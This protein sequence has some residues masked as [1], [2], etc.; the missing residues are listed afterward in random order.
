MPKSNLKCPRNPFE[1]QQKQGRDPDLA[2]ILSY[3]HPRFGTAVVRASRSLRKHGIPHMLIGG[4]AIGAYGHVR[5]TADVDFLVGDEAFELFNGGS[6][7]TFSP[8]VPLLVGEVTI[9]SIP[10]DRDGSE[11]FLAEAMAD[12]PES[13][14]VPVAPPEVL[15]YL[16]LK[17]G[18]Q[19]DLDDVRQLVRLTGI[20]QEEVVAYLDEHSAYTSSATFRR[21]V[22]KA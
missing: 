5:A 4:V 6:L 20:S 16:K 14:G 18:R 12:A 8:G 22:E 9:D 13:D 7:V 21:L 3:L 2:H 1:K 17:I 19:K 15:I 11:A 10:L